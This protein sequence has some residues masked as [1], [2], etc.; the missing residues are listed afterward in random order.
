MSHMLLLLSG[1]NCSSQYLYLCPSHHCMRPWDSFVAASKLFHVTKVF[2]LTDAIW[3]FSQAGYVSEHTHT[4]MISVRSS[5][6]RRWIT[7]TTYGSIQVL[8]E[9]KNHVEGSFFSRNIW[10]TD[11]LHLLRLRNWMFK[12]VMWIL[13]L[14]TES[15][16][17][18]QL[19]NK[20]RL[21]QVI[22]FAILWPVIVAFFFFL[23][24]H[25]WNCSFLF[26]KNKLSLYC[27]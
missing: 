5:P 1:N 15:D 17:L 25:G 12:L 26:S 20:S 18:A 21:F 23:P 7:S 6:E 11:W 13:A 24:N 10:S 16:H 4:E 19:T 9:I 3:W 2:H 14:F 27:I 22:N 8:T